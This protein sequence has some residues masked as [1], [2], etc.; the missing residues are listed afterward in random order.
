MPHRAGREVDAVCAEAGVEL[1]VTVQRRC[2]PVYAAM[3]TLPRPHRHLGRRI[4][5]G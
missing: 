3:F 5:G 4:T 2:H 1:M